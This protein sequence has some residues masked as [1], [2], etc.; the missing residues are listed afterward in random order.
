VATSV[1]DQLAGHFRRIS[2]TIK[3]IQMKQRVAAGVVGSVLLVMLLVLFIVYALPV[4]GVFRTRWLVRNQ[5]EMWIV[6]TPLPNAAPEA[7][8]GLT[9]S[10]YGY[11]FKV[12]WSQLEQERK[13]KSMTFLIFANGSV[14]VIHD[15]AQQVQALEVMK[16]TEERPGSTAKDIFG[17]NATRSNYAFQSKILYLTPGDLRLSW[18]RREMVAK[19]V[20][21]LLKPVYLGVTKSRVY[22]FQTEWLRGFQAGDPQ[23]D[24]ATIVDGFDAQ[25]RKIVLWVGS[26][27][28]APKPSQSEVNVIINSLHPVGMASPH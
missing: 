21:I 12:P 19:S 10:Y 24:K 8:K 27:E 1:H 6:P 11:E 22:S 2:G 18:S 4:Y 16:D 9:F 13:G 23:I 7:S 25:D 3:L 26:H 20:L 28:R 5:P 15:P 17:D 14:V